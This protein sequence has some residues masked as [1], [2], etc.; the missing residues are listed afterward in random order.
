MAVNKA[1]AYKAYLIFKSGKTIK[2]AIRIRQ[3]MHL[4]EFSDIDKENTDKGFEMFI[5]EK[6]RIL[7][8]RLES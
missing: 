5:T 4:V 2:T 6:I 3:T 8:I 1:I 7:R